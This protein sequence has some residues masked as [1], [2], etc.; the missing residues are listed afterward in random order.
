MSESAEAFEG[1]SLITE[2]GE[3]GFDYSLTGLLEDDDQAAYSREPNLYTEAN[4]LFLVS[5]LEGAQQASYSATATDSG[6]QYHNAQTVTQLGCGCG[7]CNGGKPTLFS[8]SGSVSTDSESLVAYSGDGAVFSGKPTATPEQFADYMINGFWQDRGGA[9]HSWSQD[10]ITY[11][12]SNSYTAAQKAGFRMAFDQWQDVAGITFSEVG[13]GGMIDVRVGNDG[14]AYSSSSRIGSDIVSNFI[15]VDTSIGG[16]QNFNTIGDYALLTAIHEIGHSLGLGHTGNYNGSGSYATDAIW[17][18]DTR[19]YSV[20]SYFNANN[21]GADHSD[22][23]GW[24]YGS[25]PALYDILAIQTIY[26]A[27]NTI[28]T[29]NTTYGFNSNAGRTQFDFTITNDPVVAIWDAGGTD[30]LDLSG[31]T[32]AQTIRLGA[33]EFS[34][35]GGMTGNVAIAFGTAIENATGGSGADS[36]YGNTANNILLGGNGNDT[37]FAS[38]GSDTLNGQAGTDIASYLSYSVTAFAFDFIDSVTV[39]FRH[40]V[41]SWTDML[42]NI[43]NFIF[44][45]GTYTFAELQDAFGGDGNDFAPT[46][47]ASNLTLEI[48]EVVLASTVIAAADADGNTLSYEVWDSGTGNASGYFELAGNRLGAGIGHTLTQAQFN[49]L[50]IVG[51]DSAI[52]E[53][54][55]VRVYDGEHKTAWTKFTLDTVAP[56]AGGDIND[57]APTV[58][59]NHFSLEIDEIALA[60]TVITAADAD[61]NTLTYEVWDGGSAIASGYFELAGSRLSAG[62]GHVLTEAQ[63][64]TLNIIGGDSAGSDTLWVRVSDGEHTTAWRSFTLETLAGGGGGGANAFAPTVTADDL[65]LDIDEVVL[66]STVITAADADGN[67]LSYEVWDSSGSGASGYFELGGTRLGTGAGHILTQ[68]EFN[69]LNIVGGDTVGK[70][71]LWVRVSDGINMTAW[72]SFTLDTVSG[73]NANDFAPAVTASNVTLDIDMSVLAT[74]AITAADADGNTLSYEVWDG[75]TAGTSGY[76]DLNGTRLGAGMTHALTQAQFTALRIVGG[77]VA[78]QEKL[79]VKVSDGYHTTSWKAFDLTTTDPGAMNGDDILDMGHADDIELGQTSQTTV[80]GENNDL[81]AAD[82]FSS[83]GGFEEDATTAAL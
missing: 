20:M 51:G 12:L 15:S 3:A 72:E 68:A 33:G 45:D 42:S 47:T 73:G 81:Y 39:S 11:S 37:L 30:T 57:Y 70:D 25:T 62:K 41:Q 26:G 36:I 49:A 59:A 10:N 61:G 56:D 13:S 6:S 2:G 83:V 1:L 53:T 54:L 55:W 7:A 82:V 22:A 27:N 9:A 76:F 32:V 50:T 28:R 23:N 69:T 4:D 46:V 78:G 67:A 17:A 34:D 63:F 18:N 77:D 5:T 16:W 66:A 44:S 38:T 74:A 35:V 60:S 64:N 40:L 21:S 48:D 24:Q 79:W 8:E 80:S 52:R 58:T 29:G 75:G 65:A 43:E 19:Q 71:T 31:Y 14:S